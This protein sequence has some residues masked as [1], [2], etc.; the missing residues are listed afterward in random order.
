MNAP[1]EKHDLAWWQALDRAHF[2]HPMTDHKDLAAKGTRVIERGEGVYVY[3]VDGHRILD[4]MSGLWCVNVGYGRRELIDAAAMQLERLPYYNSFFQCTHTGAIE[5]AAKLTALTPG[6]EHVFFTNSGSEAVDTVF[7]MVRRY[8]DLK[9]QPYR[10]TIIGRVNGYHGSTVAGASLG[11]MAAM[12]AQGDLP[13]PGVA[14]IP[15]PYWYAEGGDLSPHEFGLARARLL[16]EKILQ[17]GPHN[18]AAFI[19]EPIQGS[20]G[21]IVPPESYWPEIAR[22]CREY[23]ILLVCDEVICG[24][25][26]LGRWFGSQYYGVE[27]DLMPIAKGLSSGYIPI[28]G[29]LV[30][31]RVAD[32]LIEE[33]GE[34]HH[35]YT[36]SGHPVACAVA[37]ANL[38]V[39]L[40]ER[41]VER[42]AQDIGPYLQS[43]WAE[44]ADHPLVGQTR[45]VGLVAAMELVRDKHRRRFFEPVG[46][47]GLRA[48]D[49][50]IE[51]GLVMRAVRDTMI[52][53]PPLVITRAQVDEL[54]ATARRVLDRTAAEFAT[55]G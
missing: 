1:N 14:H 23:G 50:S 22:I 2:L 35:G 18:V 31:R 28:G 32:T 51:E 34:F 27:P 10:K 5:L 3:D 40:R 37:S 38:D 36:Y 29:V 17:L 42:V 43:R 19:A 53:A 33:G 21:V 13:I 26:R 52:I 16:E 12:H 44:L 30:G 7:R 46:V 39:M 15:Q 55:G 4:G 54:V 8:W 11:G 49:I 45:G 9:K 20:G 6:Y 24:F 47:V 25:G 41:L 48:R